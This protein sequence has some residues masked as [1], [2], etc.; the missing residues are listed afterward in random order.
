MNA[1]SSAN[2]SLA[3]SANPGAAEVREAFTQFVGQTF[4]SHMMKAMRSTQGKPAYFHGGRAEEV[5][6]GQLDHALVDA[7][8]DSSSETFAQPI[9]E[10]QFPQHAAALKA[11]EAANG[12]VR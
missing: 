4:F 5:F 6:Q 1:I 2:T 12:N 9:F 11:Y 10:H 8:A 3:T 7:M